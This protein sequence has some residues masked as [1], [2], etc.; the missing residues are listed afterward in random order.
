MREREA[1]NNKSNVLVQAR[2]LCWLMSVKSSIIRYLSKAV[3]KMPRNYWERTLNI[4][5]IKHFWNDT[6]EKKITITTTRNILIQLFSL[7][8]DSKQK[9]Q[10]ENIEYHSKVTSAQNK[11]VLFFSFLFKRSFLAAQHCFIK[12]F[13]LQQT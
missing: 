2:H 10:N 5:V 7:T 13:H 11:E 6:F 8:V 12:L 4:A 9:K 3:V 1:C